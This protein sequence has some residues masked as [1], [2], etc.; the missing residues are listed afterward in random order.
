M[1]IKDFLSREIEYKWGAVLLSFFLILMVFP[2]KSSEG[3][4][5]G[6][7]VAW[8]FAGGLRYLDEYILNIVAPG[9][10][11]G[12]PFWGSFGSPQKVFVSLASFVVG[13]FIGAKVSGEFSRNF[14]KT[15]VVDGVI[16]GLLM[17]IGIFSSL[18]KKRHVATSN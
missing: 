13:G 5:Q 15:A 3:V 16:G 2:F 8:A 9:Y 7:G 6:Y 12:H 1:G 10:L 4:T 14:D 17:G 11:A 18:L